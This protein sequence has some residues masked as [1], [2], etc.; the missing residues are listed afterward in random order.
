MISSY[1]VR[2]LAGLAVLAVLAAPPVTAQASSDLGH[3][4][5]PPEDYRSPA[6]LDDLFRPL[7]GNATDPTVIRVPRISD[8][9]AE[10]VNK[11][12]LQVH[13]IK[14]EDGN[15]TILQRHEPIET[16]GH[17][18]DLHPEHLAPV[19]ETEVIPQGRGNGS[20]DSLVRVFG[21]PGAFALDGNTTEEKVDS[22][23]EKLDLPPQASSGKIYEEVTVP[24][25]YDARTVCLSNPSP[26]SSN[27]T[28]NC[29]PRQFTLRC[30]NC[31][32]GGFATG[33]AERE[34]RATFGNESRVHVDL[35]GSGLMWFTPDGSLV[36]AEFNYAFDLNE[37]A[38]L[39]PGTAEEQA[40]QALRDRGYNVTGGSAPEERFLRTTLDP[41]R[42]EVDRVHYEWTFPVR[43]GKVSNETWTVRGDAAFAEV[44]QDAVT[45]ELRSVRL[46]PTAIETAPSDGRGVPGAA[47]LAPFAAVLA[48]LC[49]ER[50]RRGS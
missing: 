24:P 50:R 5:W 45:G 18:V 20:A 25:L 16:G 23:V 12:T 2:A 39:A 17:H 21:P 38:I 22:L 48:A 36:A 4:T 26:T 35:D 41:P 15:H 19:I 3:V 9:R 7:F 40:T 30:E 33:D 43:Q 46:G 32:L 31:S 13:V 8:I 44:V 11:T 37:S 6:T 1:S 49:A 29:N 28:G 10:P 42:V 47:W 27:E 34:F 14:R